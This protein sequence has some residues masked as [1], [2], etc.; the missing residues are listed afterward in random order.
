[1]PS[2]LIA[3]VKLNK[4]VSEA[5]WTEGWL[6]DGYYRTITGHHRRGESPAFTGSSVALIA[7]ARRFH[8]WRSLDAVP[9]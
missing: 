8:L 4:P 6:P 5:L 2:K 9:A 7:A 3:A 1:M